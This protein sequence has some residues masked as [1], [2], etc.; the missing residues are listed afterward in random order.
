MKI[1]QAKLLSEVDGSEYQV[2]P[3]KIR[4]ILERLAATEPRNRKSMKQ[5]A[6][7]PRKPKRKLL[8]SG[9]TCPESDVY[10]LVDLTGDLRYVFKGGPMPPTPKPGMAFVRK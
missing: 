1:V 9:E 7:E 3:L 5:L 4:P 8:F 10:E 6:G 2:H